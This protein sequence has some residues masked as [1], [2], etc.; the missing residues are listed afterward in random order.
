MSNT[1][2]LP[3]FVREPILRL[4]RLVSPSRK[5]ERRRPERGLRRGTGFGRSETDLPFAPTALANSPT[6][7]FRAWGLAGLLVSLFF[8]ASFTGC[9]PKQVGTILDAE[10][11]FALAK[12]EFEE[13]NY[14]QANTEFQK[15]IFNYPGAVFIDSAQ[16]FLAMSNFNQED[17]PLAVMEFN[18]LISSFPTSQL[19]DDAAFMVALC[20]FKMS[21]KAELDQKH[22]EQAIEELQNFLDDYPTSDRANEAQDLLRESRSKLA[23]KS[24]KNGQLYFKMRKYDAA[25]IYLEEVVNGFHDT[26]WA[27]PAQFQIAEVYLKQKKYDRAKEEFERFLENFPQD[28]LAKKAKQ[29]LEKLN[30][31]TGH[32]EK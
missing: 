4:P 21:A 25:L 12:R 17:Y 16:Y 19:S 13:E 26:E 24:Y 3:A 31:G 7:K 14:R 20:D 29:R 10:D 9:G 18:K 30:S 27:A 15:L 6:M 28:K 32:A 22:T 5:G 11:Q 8:I 23:K 2:F 1:F